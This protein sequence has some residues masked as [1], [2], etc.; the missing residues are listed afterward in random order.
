MVV[1]KYLR[2]VDNH[3]AVPFT[4][5][6]WLIRRH[7]YNSQEPPKALPLFTLQTQTDLDLPK[8]P[9]KYMHNY[10]QYLVAHVIS[11]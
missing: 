9:S 2:G 1:L 3:R 5:N 8:T 6:T 7:L 10:L 4:W 11:A